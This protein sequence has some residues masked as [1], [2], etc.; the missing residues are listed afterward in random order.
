MFSSIKKY[1]IAW[2]AFITVLACYPFLF[3]LHPGKYDLIDC[4][5]PWRFYVGECLQN[6]QFPVWNPYQ[7]LGYPIHAD[8]SSGAWY[9]IVWL[10][11]YFKGYS[12]WLIGFEYSLH[13]FLA[14]VG[15][16]VLL[17]GLNFEKKFAFAGAVAYM[18]SGFM[19][20]NAQHLPYVI[21]ACW[22]P[23]IIHFYL[24]MLQ[25][26]C[27]ISALKTAFFLFLSLSGG[28]PAVTIILF[29]FCLLVFIYFFIKSFKAKESIWIYFKLGALLL[30]TTV[31]LS[32]GLFV[33][34]Y[35]V[36]PF[37]SRL[38]DFNLEQAQ[39]S[40]FSPQSFISFLFPLAT[41]TKTLWFDSDLSM[42]NAF[43]GVIL[44]VFYLLAF[45]IKKS[46]LIKI[47]FYFGLFSL[48]AAVGS[49]LPVRALLYDFIPGMNVFRFP[50]VFRL[51]FI[52]SAIVVALYYWQNYFQTKHFSTK[53]WLILCS[54]FCFIFGIIVIIAR[55]KGYLGMQ[56][57]IAHDLWLSI[58][59]ENIWTPM[60]FQAFVYVLLFMGITI[61]L[62][63]KFKPQN[64]L[65]SFLVIELLVALHLNAPATIYNGALKTKE[66]EV[67][68]GQLTKGFKP[69]SAKS[70]I[71]AKSLPG[72]GQPFWQNLAI[73]QKEISAEGFNSFC[74]LNYEKLESNY[75]KLF[76]AI[77]NNNV[78]L[79]SAK[80][81]PIAQMKNIAQK[82]SIPAENVYLNKQDFKALNLAKMGHAEQDTAFMLAYSANHF[83]VQVETAKPQFLVLFQQY[84]SGWGV[85]IDGKDA[86][87]LKSHDNFMTVEVPKGT[88]YIQFKYENKVLNVAKWL[89]ILSLFG[90]GI[91]ILMVSIQKKKV[92]SSKVL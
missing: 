62:V 26:K 25:H 44:F 78:L 17:K 35:Q 31:I 64:V 3:K 37:L 77:Q 91:F 32:A 90:L 11:G 57:F 76:N 72:L 18:L 47:F 73:F 1:P 82:D 49:Y 22:L 81:L 50:S 67:L 36:S 16:Y 4:F 40:P 14:G 53:K 42:R 45:S 2:L 48:L 8:P 69:L 10:L 20:G 80:V 54:I 34:I 33:A 39:F 55:S 71:E 83:D 86:L 88:H 5:Y 28:Y 58:E 79:L 29:Y 13:I 41:T 92:P 7:D 84:Y 89:S 12:L 61:L 15:A 56:Q 74:F 75:P 63:L 51:F 52:L 70:I 24:Q 68:V 6:G 19:V 46:G 87:L 21:S 59:N 27:Y 85:K 65:V 9:P 38:G 66:S 23:Y 30:F 60:A 43:F